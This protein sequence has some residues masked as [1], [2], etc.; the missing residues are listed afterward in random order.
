MIRSLQSVGNPPSKP[1]Q[2]AA[3][4]DCPKKADI[5]KCTVPAYTSAEEIF[6]FSA[7]IAICQKLS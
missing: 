3:D 4:A 5:S 2:F 6:F 1:V 7:T